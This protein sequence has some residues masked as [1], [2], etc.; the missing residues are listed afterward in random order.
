[1]SV[2]RESARCA[3]L[4]SLPRSLL[5]RALKHPLLVPACV[6]AFFALLGVVWALARPYGASVDEE[7]HYVRALGVSTGD[8]IGEP[9]TWRYNPLTPAQQRTIDAA[10]RRVDLPPRVAA[11]HLPSGE[12]LIT[13]FAVRTT[14]SASCIGPPTGRV[15]DRT[16][17]GIYP[18]VPYVVPGLAARPAD[19]PGGGLLLARLASG[20][21]C[22]VVLA[23]CL[24]GV[25]DRA[26]PGLS[27]LGVIVALSPTV[28]YFSWSMNAN[29]LE[30]VAGIAFVALCLR[31]VREAPAPGWLWSVTAL[32]GFLLGTSRPLAFVWVFFGVWVAVLLHGPSSV[33][34][35]ARRGGRPAALMIAVLAATVLAVVVWNFLVNARTP[36]GVAAW[37]ELVKPG[38][39]QVLEGFLPEQIAVSGWGETVLPERL[40]LVWKVV[41]VGLGAVAFAV[42][43]WRQRLA[44]FV[45]LV[46]YL[47]GVVLLT[48][49]TQA[50][51]FPMGGRYFQPI[52]TAFPLVWGEVIL[53]NRHRLAGWLRPGLVAVCAAVVAV[54]NGA[55]LLANGRR[56][57]VGT[58]GAWSYLVDGGLWA[59]PGGWLPWV[60]LTVTGMVVLV[61]AF[62]AYGEGTTRRPHDRMRHTGATL[63]VAR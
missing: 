59:P 37:S 49:V 8:L 28:L 46:T 35:A 12:S 58:D 16:Y 56:Y 27:L 29:G 33:V 53:A 55:A 18:P 14:D 25:H 48:R 51:G 38:L 45:L 7:A 60:V 62:V 61:V 10:T 57:S 21:V 42:G 52:F 54:V 41:F 11:R 47:A 36:G 26:A 44:P 2:T 39:R 32:V 1:M 17:V 4:T 9:D 63:D 6:L 22:T 50:G 15:V 31:L 19:G 40:Y 34:R 3:E 20:I 24:L 30:M 13:C 43:T 5:T 23:L